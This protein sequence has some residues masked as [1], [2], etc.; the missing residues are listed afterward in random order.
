MPA[1]VL[2]IPIIFCLLILAEN[3]GTASKVMNRT[4]VI[5]MIRSFFQDIFWK[6]KDSD[7]EFLTT[8]IR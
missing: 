5:L 8:S 4:F 6:R 3:N 7:S 1:T 2:T